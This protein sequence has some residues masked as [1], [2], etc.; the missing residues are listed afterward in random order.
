MSVAFLMRVKVGEMTEKER[1]RN[2][3]GLKMRHIETCEKTQFK[4]VD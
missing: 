3:E 2:G 1:R 4:A